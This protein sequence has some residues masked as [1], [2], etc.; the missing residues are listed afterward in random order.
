[1]R[2]KRVLWLPGTD[3]AAIATQTAVEKKLRAET[4]QIRHDL[5]KELFLR[6]VNQFVQET[7]SVIIKQIKAMGA[8][9]DWSRLAFTLDEPRQAAVKEM[10]CQLYEAGLL[11]R[12]ERVVNWCPRCASTLADDEVEYQTRAAK[13]YTFFY[14][15]NFPFPIATTRPETKLGDTAVCVNP[16]DS[17]YAVYLGR[18][19]QANFCQT[20]L[21]LRVIS[22]RGV[23][24]NFG[25]GA[26]GVTPGHSIA[27]WLLAQTNN[28]P[29]IKVIDEQ[30][31]I[32]P[33]FGKF[34]GLKVLAARELLVSDLRAAGLLQQEE[35][36]EN[37]QPVCYRCGT[38]IEPLLSKQWFVAVDKPLE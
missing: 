11:Y 19:F 3:H 6:K 9:L 2:G 18:E 12:G 14:D 7:Q 35:D 37:N 24:Q 33:G 38:A 36:I 22:D 34:S 13:L 27:D 25:T 28:L 31:K 17:R 23:D 29:L 8:S 30:A 4:G 5:G 1:M 21:R 16:Q 32:R 26:L 10:F 20:Q 15:R